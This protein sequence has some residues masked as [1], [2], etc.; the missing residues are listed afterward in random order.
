MPPGCT[1]L[2]AVK[3]PRLVVVSVR[4][5]GEGLVSRSSNSTS[6]GELTLV[7][8]WSVEKVGGP[9]V[10]ETSESFG[11]TRYTSTRTSPISAGVAPP[12]SKPTNVA[13]WRRACQLK[14][15]SSPVSIS[16]F[17]AVVGGEGVAILPLGLTVLKKYG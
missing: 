13:V 14:M 11:K 17:P 5:P 6:E 4:L 12:R 15:K 8:T 7:G 2:S 16:N 3:V 1:E 9:L 10:R